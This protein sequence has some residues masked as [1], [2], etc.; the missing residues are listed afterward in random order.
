MQ[1]IFFLFFFTTRTRTL[2]GCEHYRSY[3]YYIEA[4]RSENNPNTV[5]YKCADYETFSKD[6]RTCRSC[7]TNRKDCV[8][9]G[10]KAI[11]YT[12]SGNKGKFYLNTANKDPYFG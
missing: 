11:E 2:L 1:T 7:G 8:Y 3:V 12:G 9:F 10:P 4:I 5:A 6:N